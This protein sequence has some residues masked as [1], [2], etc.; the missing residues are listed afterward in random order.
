LVDSGSHTYVD[1][2]WLRLSGVDDPDALGRA[3]QAVVDRTPALRSLPVWEG[4]DEPLQVVHGHA[5]VPVDHHDWRG[6]PAPEVD[7]RLRDVL[8]DGKA[9]MALTAPPLLRVAVARLAD[10][11]VVLAWTWHHLLLD[12][13]S[14]GLVFAEVCERYAAI[15]AGRTPR[16]SAR[17]PFRDYLR[18]LGEQDPRAAEA[19]WRTVL[20]D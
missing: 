3:W 14:V 11:E 12:G 19:H 17:R 6:L 9:S 20:S 4:V 18:W 10:D 5:T 7:D 8:D 16:V 13:W 15:V 2:F 1:Q